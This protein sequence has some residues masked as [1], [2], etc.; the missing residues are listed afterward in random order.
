MRSEIIF[1]DVLRV[2]PTIHSD[3]RG[4]F[5]EDYNY[6]EFS[7]IGIEDT[8]VQDN[9][10]LSLKRNTVRGMH[11]QLKPFSQSKLIKVLSGSIFDVFI[12]LRTQSKT[13]EK[14]G[15]MTLS[16]GEGWLYIPEGFA[17]GFCTL[18]D[19]TSVL[20]KVNNIYNPDSDSGIIYDDN[21][22]SINW[23][24]SRN[25]VILS[26]KDQNLSSWEEIKDKVEL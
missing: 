25:Q 13:Y 19:N 3:E 20:Y 23:P 17:H 24:I 4:S 6:E 1:S 8:F 26:E 5:S 18:E 15:S 22:F 11:F 7:K 14:Y 16:Y 12:D 9:I 2:E 21:F 10:S